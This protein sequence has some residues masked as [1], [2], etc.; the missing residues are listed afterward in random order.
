VVIRFGPWT[1]AVCACCAFVTRA[2]DHQAMRIDAHIHQYDPTR[3]EGVP[4]PPKALEALAGPHLPGD[5]RAVSAGTGITHAIVVEASEWVT[6]ND[7]LLSLVAQD[8][9]ILGIVGNL[10]PREEDFAENLS[11][12]ARHPKF[13]GIRP[14]LYPSPRLSDPQ[15]AANLGRLAEHGLTLEL[16]VPEYPWRD[17]AAFARAHPTLRLVVNHLAGA[18]LDEGKVAPDWLEAIAPFRSLPNTYCKLSAFYTAA[19]TQP[20]PTDPAFYA[21]LLDALLDVF[22]PDR[23]FFG[24]NW[25]VSDLGG[26]Y[27]PLPRLV[28]TYASEH[29]PE[30]VDAFFR[31][32]TLKA[33]GLDGGKR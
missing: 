4:W 3:A 6:D 19:G 5:F 28:E 33:Y 14:R 2:G 17:A 21:G 23:L 26:P 11:R 12:L 20:A 9:G 18:R 13:L 7:W 30:W 24:S 15:V 8:D 29:S 32:N 10:D 31:V 25:P 16:N 27:G 1:A 22:G